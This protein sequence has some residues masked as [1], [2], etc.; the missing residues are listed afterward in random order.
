MNKHLNI[1]S[2]VK[3]LLALFMLSA[4]YV[5]FAEQQKLELINEG[6]AAFNDGN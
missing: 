1:S 5:A 3:I 4:N 6:V 2:T